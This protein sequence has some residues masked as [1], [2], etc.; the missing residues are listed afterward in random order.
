MARLD[1]HMLFF[2]FLV[3]IHL[4]GVSICEEWNTEAKLMEVALKLLI[5]I[6]DYCRCSIGITFNQ[7]EF[8]CSD[9]SPDYITFQGSYGVHS[10]RADDVAQI[11]QQW[12]ASQPSIVVSGDVL[13]VISKVTIMCPVNISS[14]NDD[15]CSVVAVGEELSLIVPIVG[16]VVS[17]FIL[18]SITILSAVLLIALRKYV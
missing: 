4:K 6:N 7:T 5:D 1:V 13:N 17:T 2:K 18:L 10:N 12:V 3:Q 14:S 15:D 11:I 9:N 8:K 16:G